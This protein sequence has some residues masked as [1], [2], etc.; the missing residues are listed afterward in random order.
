M[1]YGVKLG[2][3]SEITW[4]FEKLLVDRQGNVVDRFAP[5]IK[6]DDAVITAAIEKALTAG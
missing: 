5:D 3:P 2:A 4:N 6:P 1:G